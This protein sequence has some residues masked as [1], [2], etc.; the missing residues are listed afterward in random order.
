[1]DPNTWGWAEPAILKNATELL[2]EL[3]DIVSKNGNLLLNVPPLADG[4]FDPRVVATLEEMG[5]WLS[6]NGAAIFKSKPWGHCCEDGGSIT[7][8]GAGLEWPIYQRGD[9]R[10]TT[11][12]GAIFVIAFG[13]PSGGSATV[14][15]LNSTAKLIVGTKITAVSVI[16]APDLQPQWRVTP[17]GL[18]LS[19]LPSSKPRGLVRFHSWVLRVH[20]DGATA[21]AI[22]APS[23]QIRRRILAIGS[24]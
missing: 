3:A 1:M 10:F 23:L 20:L 9:Y 6:L 22:D 15:S 16:G 13:W 8:L 12:Q 4:S 17:T 19:E 14:V 2:G 5:D 11:T 18:Q 24:D 7:G 21:A